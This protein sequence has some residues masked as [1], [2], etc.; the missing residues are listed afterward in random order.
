VHVLLDDHGEE[1]ESWGFEL[2]SRVLLAP[3]QALDTGK[4]AE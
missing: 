4:E 2:W 1:D 3:R